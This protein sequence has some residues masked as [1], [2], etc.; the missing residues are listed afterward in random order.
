MKT[1][2][3]WLSLCGLVHSAHASPVLPGPG[4]YRDLTHRIRPGGHFRIYMPDGRH[5]DVKYHFKFA[6]PLYAA[7]KVTDQN[8]GFNDTIRLFW[9]RI[10]LTDESYLEVGGE[11]LPL[12]CVFVS[13]QD[14]R[15]SRGGP[16][17]PEFL[18]RIYLVANDFACEGPIRKGWPEIGGKK[19]AWDTYLHYEVKDPTIMLPQD[20]V[21]RYR[22]NESSAVLI[23]AGGAP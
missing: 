21:L 11:R 17:T 14:N 10:L 6:S 7:P 20:A 1:L 2:A 5:Q 15:F 22:W 16:L 8:W 9:D 13:G 23:D 3:L 18:I 12:T 4:F 19:E